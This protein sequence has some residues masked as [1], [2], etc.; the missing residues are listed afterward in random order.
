MYNVVH[1]GFPGHEAVRVNVDLPGQLI[2][3]PNIAAVRILHQM[4]GHGAYQLRNFVDGHFDFWIIGQ[5]R[6]PR[7]T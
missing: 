7:N 2:A 6:I 3:Y 4:D 5:P 1:P